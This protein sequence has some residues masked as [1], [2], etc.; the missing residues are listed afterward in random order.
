MSKYFRKEC[1]VFG[2]SCLAYFA[3]GMIYGLGKVPQ[4][5]NTFFVY[6]YE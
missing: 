6:S 1:F 2:V 4:T 3:L 5:R